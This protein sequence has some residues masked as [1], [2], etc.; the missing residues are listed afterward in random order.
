MKIA[1][2]IFCCRSFRNGS[3]LGCMAELDKSLKTKT[4]CEELGICQGNGCASCGG[5]S[6]PFAPDAIEHS[7]SQPGRASVWTRKLLRLVFRAI[8]VAAVL[9]ALYLAWWWPEI[10]LDAQAKHAQNMLQA[11]TVQCTPE[12]LQ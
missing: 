3:C 10:W 1:C 6:Y 8:V 11:A 12:G 7:R 2:L 9:L 4:R 5:T